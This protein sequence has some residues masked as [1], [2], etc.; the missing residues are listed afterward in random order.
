MILREFLLRITWQR[1]SSLAQSMIWR[2]SIRRL[3]NLCEATSGVSQKRGTPSPT[4]GTVRPSLLSP[5]DSITIRS[6]AP[7]FTAR[8]P[9]PSMNSSRLQTH[10]HTPNK[11][12]GSSRTTLLVLPARI[13]THV[14][15]MIATKNGVM[16][17]ATGATTIMNAVIMIGQRDQ[18]LHSHVAVDRKTS[19]T[20]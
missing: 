13:T 18:G 10:T 20:T 17:I 15:M 4:S 16:K 7:N 14:V 2:N 3:G 12:I 8:G 1:V 5:K 19:S 9:R 11:L 6:Y